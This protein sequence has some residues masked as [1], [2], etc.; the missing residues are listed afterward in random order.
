MAKTVSNLPRGRRTATCR[1]LAAT[2]RSRMHAAH[3]APLVQPAA[4]EECV[5]VV[6]ARSAEAGARADAWAG[7]T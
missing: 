3:A 6:S 5:H 4:S 1:R 7:E 2:P